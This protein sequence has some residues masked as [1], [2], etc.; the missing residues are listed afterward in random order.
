MCD[1][2]E[3]APIVPGTITP[4]PLP[5]QTGGGVKVV[6]ELPSV[7]DASEGVIYVYFTDLSDVSTFSGAYVLDSTAE[8]LVDIST[9]GGGGHVYTFEDTVTGFNVLQDGVKIY[10]HTD[11]NT[12]YSDFVGTDGVDPGTAGLVPA[13]AV[14]DEDKYLKADG[15]WGTV[16]G[17]EEALTIATTD[18]TALSNASPYDYSATVTAIT[19]IGANSTVE[20]VNDQAV[21][22][23]TYG[24]AI[25][26]ISGQDVTI[27]SIGQPDTSV[28]LTIKV[29]S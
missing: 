16:A 5:E 12:T 8:K 28:T 14:G 22:F 2:D 29:R 9:G 26:A 17:T 25:G 19:T 18:W 7:A 23:G 20:L 6:S 10:E 3:C 24:F 15:T 11:I 4:E 21:L 1:D 13:P 27:Y